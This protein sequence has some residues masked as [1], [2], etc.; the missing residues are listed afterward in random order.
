MRVLSSMPF[1]PCDGRR[2]SPRYLSSAARYTTPFYNFTAIEALGEPIW[3]P[4]HY[5]AF[6]LRA[7]LPEQVYLIDLDEAA[8]ID[9]LI[10]VYRTAIVG[11]HSMNEWRALGAGSGEIAFGPS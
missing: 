6:V 1:C 9:Q 10:N 2:V 5:L 8:P 7:G 3:Q 11:E 4:P